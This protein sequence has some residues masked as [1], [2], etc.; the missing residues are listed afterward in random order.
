MN[1]TC[2]AQMGCETQ[3]PTVALPSQ[4]HRLP[5]TRPQ[6]CLR[7]HACWPLS[8]KISEWLK[9]PRQ[10]KKQK[11]TIKHF[12]VGLCFN[13]VFIFYLPIEYG[14]GRFGLASRVGKWGAKGLAGILVHSKLCW[15]VLYQLGT[16]Y[17][18][19]KGGSLN[20]SGRWRAL[21]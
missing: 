4:H 6:V 14:G 7:R 11:K 18:Y 9:T 12:I 1:T 15:I 13:R 8:R 3:T 21:S 17:S 10:K 19:L 2:A 16:S 20:S 5:N